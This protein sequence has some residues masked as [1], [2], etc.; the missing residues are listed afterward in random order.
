MV[1][2]TR[3]ATLYLLRDVQPD[4]DGMLAA[5]LE[6]EPDPGFDVQEVTVVDA[7]ALWIEGSYEREVAEW[8]A[9][10]STTT[11]LTVRRASAQ[12]AGLLI[13]AVDGAVYAV[14]YGAGHRLVPDH[15]KDRRF[16]LRF[17]VRKLDADQVQDL[18]RRS[19]GT[20]GR[21]DA[22]YIPAGLPIWGYDV[23]EQADIVGRAGGRSRPIPLTYCSGIERDVRFEGATGLRLRLGVLPAH[24]VS[25]IRTIAGIIANDPPQPSLEF[26][27]RVVPVEDP[28]TREILNDELDQI[29]ALPDSEAAVA[30][31]PVVPMDCV[32]LLSDTRSFSVK[33]GGAAAR[34]V[35]SVQLSDILARTRMQKPGQRLESLRRGRVTLHSDEAAT[36][37]LRGS[38]ADHWLEA[39]VRIGWDRFALFDGDW[40]QVDRGYL[41]SLRRQVDEIL[42]KPSSVHLPPW[43]L[44]WDERRYNEDVGDLQSGYVCLD[45]RG[46]RDRLHNRAGVEACDLLGPDDELIHVKR[47]HG[48]APLSHLFSQGSVAAR[49]LKNSPDA[50]KHL[51]ARVAQFKPGRILTA[52]FMPKKVV[53]GI[54]L[55][56]GERLTTDTL[57]PFSQVSLVSTVR[58]LRKDGVD[59]E[60]VAIEGSSRIAPISSTFAKR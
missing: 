26:I 60:V 54:M 42:S 2:R 7:P 35:S 6:E 21:T 8:C 12:P 9:D 48:S 20:R 13:I 43:D 16:G 59:V 5:Y 55:K 32:P 11:G 10:A 17:A 30:V 24:L 52:D 56:D 18:L 37:A 29:L 39:S 36:D 23:E 53:F 49:T 15:L 4:V 57:F 50:R 40:Y 41:E 1:A 31:T 14:G 25:D 33:I 27:E 19:P 58:A 38:P 28:D 22:T 51:A 34:T 44:A 46:V 45:R 47:A 3:D